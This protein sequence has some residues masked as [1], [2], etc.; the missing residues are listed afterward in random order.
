MRENP[1]SFTMRIGKLLIVVIA[2]SALA[3]CARYYHMPR[4]SEPHATLVFD[5]GKGFD[6]RPTPLKLNGGRPTSY[7]MVFGYRRTFRI[8]L[9]T[10]RLEL[11][12]SP[13]GDSFMAGPSFTCELSFEAEEGRRYIVSMHW[14]DD[15]YLYAVTADNGTNV[16]ECKSRSG[17]RCEPVEVCPT[18]PVPGGQG[19]GEGGIVIRDDAQVYKVAKGTGVVRKLKRGDAVAVESTVVAEDVE[20]GGK[21]SPAL[22]RSYPKVALVNSAGPMHSRRSIWPRAE[23]RGKNDVHRESRPVT[24]RRGR[25]LPLG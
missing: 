5:Q 18:P 19:K 12:E 8:G 23:E 15:H 4:E 20:P 24:G 21:L 6:E 7:L 25:R 11:G 17:A 16:A 13:A 22:A 9:G 1:I 2:L 10:M 3:G 14:E